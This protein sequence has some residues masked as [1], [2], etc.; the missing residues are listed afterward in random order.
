M[1][2]SGP[3]DVPDAPGGCAWKKAPP[4]NPSPVD[5]R[6]DCRDF[7]VDGWLVQPDLNRLVGRERSVHVRPQLIDLLTCLAV[8]PGAVVSKD[9]LLASVWSDRYIAE[10]GVA[11][12]VAE[13]RQILSDDARQP[14]IIETISKRGYRLIARVERAGAGGARPLDAPHAPDAIEADMGRPA[15]GVGFVQQ[16]RSVGLRARALVSAAAGLFATWRH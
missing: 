3:R 4:M 7:F 15:A 16:S 14:R 6:A 5:A 12:C 10:S 13:L 8:R 1:P 2:V 11:R 9:Q